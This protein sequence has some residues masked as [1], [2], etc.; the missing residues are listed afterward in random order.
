MNWSIEK[1]LYDDDDTSSED[2]DNW[3]QPLLKASEKGDP[4]SKSLSKLIN[5]SCTQQCEVKQ[6][7]EKK[8]PRTVSSCRAPRV[9]DEIWG[10]LNLRNV[11]RVLRTAGNQRWRQIPYTRGPGSGWTFGQ[12]KDSYDVQ[13][14]EEALGE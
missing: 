10:D 4:I 1:R 9:N 2:D 6:T 8:F 5:D 14:S 13:H 3:P 12:K 11:K 7:I